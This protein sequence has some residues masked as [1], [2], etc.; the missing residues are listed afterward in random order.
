M[1]T[2]HRA[3]LQPSL[4]PRI[5]WRIP[6][7]RLGRWVRRLLRVLVILLLA[8]VFVLMYAPPAMAEAGS[9][10][11]QPGD[12]LLQ[13]AVDHAV[14]VG[15]LAAANRLALD[16]WVY[17][18]QRLIIPTASLGQSPS[19]D[20]PVAG[21]AYAID[22]RVPDPLPE[23]P[24]L[25]LEEPA[26]VVPFSYA[27]VVADDAPVFAEPADA[28]QALPPK[29][30]LGT[31]FVWVSVQSRVTLADRDFY[32]I[33]AGEYVAAETLSFYQPSAFRG[34]HLAAQPERPLAW[35]LKP[36][37]PTLTPAGEPNPEAPL[38]QRYQLVQ[39]FGTEHVGDQVWYLIGP[40]QWINQVTVGKVAL[41]APP[42]EVGSDER[43]IDVN[44]FEQTLAAYEGDRLVYAT[45]I[46]SGLPGWDTPTGLSQVWLRVTAGKMSGALNRPDYYFL[47]DVPW[48]QYFNQDV[49]LHTAYWHDGFGY[50]HSHGCVNL[51]PLDARWL[52]EWAP[53]GVWVS[54][55]AG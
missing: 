38:F 22:A 8:L 7:L 44:L 13:I 39:I 16:D 29:R 51:A 31:G 37:Q 43:W 40:H 33:N 11:V 21:D 17:V 54:V 15:S 36:V 34:V 24:M 25:P 18:G 49:A 32:Q 12:T 19:G 26:N 2:I 1:L 46:S 41:T 10:V 35:I 9:Y 6:R 50:K 3:V 27:R 53:E 5:T 42:E 23:L 14:S 48:T 28:I 47:E 30:T 52:F 20:Q 4:T 55:R 45:L